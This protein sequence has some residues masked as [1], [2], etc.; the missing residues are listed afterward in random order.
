MGLNGK[1][2]L[3]LNY[4]YSSNYFERRRV[5]LETKC[6]YIDYIEKQFKILLLILSYFIFIGYQLHT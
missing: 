2:L 4:T 3:Y 1:Y 5:W 6:M